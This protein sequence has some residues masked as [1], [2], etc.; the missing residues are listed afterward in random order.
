MHIFSE[1]LQNIAKFNKILSREGSNMLLVGESGVGRRLCS[2]LVTHML[3]M[4]F[5]TVNVTR[6][7][8]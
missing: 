4:Q 7:Y 8:S 2:L 3:E 1:S 5:L 6:G